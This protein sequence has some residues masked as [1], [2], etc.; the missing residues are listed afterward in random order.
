M[1]YYLITMPSEH[2]THTNEP[3]H[4]NGPVSK[5]ETLTWNKRLVQGHHGND[6]ALHTAVKNGNTQGSPTFLSRIN[7]LHYL[8][9]ALSVL[10]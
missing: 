8:P 6:S 4:H 10:F 3:Y 7:I 9:L 2:L 1:F 5:D